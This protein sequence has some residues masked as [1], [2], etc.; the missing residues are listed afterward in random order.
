[1]INHYY[2]YARFFPF[3]FEKLLFSS[4]NNYFIAFTAVQHYIDVVAIMTYY[5]MMCW[6]IL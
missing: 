5:N 2:L 1:M 4:N 6:Y 3:L